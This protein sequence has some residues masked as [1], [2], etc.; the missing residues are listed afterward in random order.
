MF[1]ADTPIGGSFLRGMRASRKRLPQHIIIFARP[2][3]PRPLQ[4]DLVIRM[5]QHLLPY[6]GPPPQPLHFVIDTAL[7]LRYVSD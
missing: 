6:E 7:L 1:R 4:A 2:L 5:P 3:R